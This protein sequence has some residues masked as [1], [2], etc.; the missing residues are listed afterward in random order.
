MVTQVAAVIRG[1]APD[2]HVEA[3]HPFFFS[4][5]KYPAYAERIELKCV[6]LSRR[7]QRETVDLS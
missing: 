1:T 4:L 3:L 2:A 7:K 5:P 6:E